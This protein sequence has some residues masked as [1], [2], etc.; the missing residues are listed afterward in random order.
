MRWL[1]DFSV[2]QGAGIALKC[3][4]CG[5]AWNGCAAECCCPECGAPKGYWPENHN[6]CF[7]DECL[8]DAALPAPSTALLFCNTER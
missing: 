1:G 6:E 8:N 5:V 3:H 2:V 7:C 4:H